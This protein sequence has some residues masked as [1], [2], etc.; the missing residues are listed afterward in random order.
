M[1]TELL[2]AD[3]EGIQKAAVL[4][5]A[6][7]LVAFPT[8]T[9]YGLGAKALMAAAVEGIYRAK[10][11]PGD[12]P[13]IVH[14]PRREEAKRYGK[15]TELADML[16]GAFWPGPLTL[17]V[18]HEGAF[19]P[20]VTA[21]LDSVALRV[22][23]HPAALALLNAAGIPV[24]APSANRSGRPSPTAARHVLEDF[25]G[26]IPLILDGGD[27]AVGLESTVVDA[28]GD[29]PLVLRPGAVTPEML[30]AVAGDCRVAESVLRQIGRDEAAPSPGMRHRHYAPRA[31]VRLVSGGEAAVAQKIRS[32]A[33]GNP[34]AL[35]LAMEGHLPRY[36]NLQVWSLGCDARDAAHRL[37]GLLREADAKGYSLILCE[38]L[39][40][41]GLGLAVMNRL[42]RAAEFDII[43]AGQK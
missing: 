29:I 32:L 18:S 28:R 30:A 6:G 1:R 21:G 2:P 12:N 37:F 19:P 43:N 25:D 15:W 16:A 5:R 35:V 31:K 22:P 24:A 8:E 41:D 34:N 4:L 39:P 9:V 7:E 11:R 40:P 23:S 17:I 10:G 27:T 33:A 20:V 14:I 36:M 38:T 3:N 26:L 13:L 42:A